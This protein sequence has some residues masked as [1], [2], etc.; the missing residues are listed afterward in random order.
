M[1]ASQAPEASA[2][3]TQR[4]AGDSED[5]LDDGLTADSFLPPEDEGE[6]EDDED[7]D[8]GSAG[9]DAGDSDEGGAGEPQA[10]KKRPRESA[11]ESDG[12]GASSPSEGLDAEGSERREKK[13]RKHKKHKKRRE[14][15]RKDDAAAP[16]PTGRNRFV[17]LEAEVSEDSDLGVSSD[18]TDD[19]LSDEAREAAEARRDADLRQ[20]AR[21]GFGAHRR[22]D[23]Q[24][25]RERDSDLAGFDADLD[26][27]DQAGPA[28]LSRGRELIAHGAL[29]A[30]GGGAV[31]RAPRR[32]VKVSQEDLLPT[33]KDP[34]MWVVKCRQGQERLAILSLMQKFVT[35]GSR[36]GGVPV[37]SAVA[38]EH[39]KGY[40]YIEAYRHDDVRSAIDKMHLFFRGTQKL[41]ALEEMP[42][43]MESARSSRV[44]TSA[45]G[46][47]VALYSL[48]RG[49]WVRVSRGVFR[50]DLAQ[51]MDTDDSRNVVRLRLLPRIQL[52][53]Q[54]DKKIR[55][56]QRLFSREEVNRQVDGAERATVDGDGYRFRGEIYD[57]SGFLLKEFNIKSIVSAKGEATVA[58]F[59]P[60]TLEEID[61]FSAALGTTAAPNGEEDDDETSVER[62]RQQNS[63]ALDLLKDL[64]VKKV[65]QKFQVGDTV[66]VTQGQLKSLSGVVENVTADTAADPTGGG[67]GMQV[68][69]RPHHEDLKDD[70]LTFPDTDL[71]KKFELGDH[72]VSVAGEHQGETGLVVA[73]D[74][75]EATVTVYADATQRE[76]TLHA[77]DVAEAS[78]TT[79]ARHKFGKYELGD[80]VS[81]GAGAVGCIVKIDAGG[82][83]RILD[84]SGRVQ[85]IRANE[86]GAK[87]NF[88]SRETVT[89][90]Q[91]QNQLRVGNM[92]RVMGGS[93]RRYIGKTA[94]IKHL[95]KFSAFCH[96]RDVVE[97]AGIFLVKPSHLQ[98]LGVQ[99]RQSGPAAVPM[100][101]GLRGQNQPRG[102]MMQQGGGGRGRGRADP[103]IS[104][105]VIVKSGPWKGY[106]GVVKN[107]TDTTCRVELHSRSKIIN[108][109]RDRVLVREHGLPRA[110]GAP[111]GS[112]AAPAVGMTPSHPGIRDYSM[113]QT[114]SVNPATPGDLG[115]SGG[116]SSAT[117]MTGT[118]WDPSVSTSSAT[119]AMGAAAPGTSYDSYQWDAQTPA[120]DL[121]MATPASMT[122][123]MDATPAQQT[124]MTD[125]PG[126]TDMLDAT[127]A[128]QQQQQARS[129]AWWE[130]PQLARPD[131]AENILIRVVV[132]GWEGSEGSVKKID[133]ASGSVVAM[134]SL[135]KEVLTFPLWHTVLVPLP[136]HVDETE[137]TRQVRVIAGDEHLGVIGQ[138]VSRH[139]NDAI[140][141]VE[142]GDDSDQILVAIE[143]LAFFQRSE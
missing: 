24:L 18:E 123:F 11:S 116:Y 2:P 120:T 57:R 126:T 43:V 81:V 63:E 12:A 4:E 25:G 34:K 77:A 104:Q 69:I 27:L 142:G 50:G 38:P 65:A 14:E 130:P 113:D 37:L 60:P 137:D 128:Q 13:R 136:E 36:N 29:P 84:H 143:N 15:R 80:L 47:K 89:Y 30:P 82:V 70:L 68:T 85:T 31:A 41:V 54:V 52:S 92:V 19:D 39:L 102:G 117:P 121:P 51:V 22:M 86:I 122:P 134:L 62:R 124:P 105:T 139:Y 114:P 61:R 127:P 133:A 32:R 94:T 107:A 6:A 76:I 7:G 112:V 111:S 75:V 125:G 115:S 132:G 99:S 45:T 8:F 91:S 108:V 90:D 119:P 71:A 26:A 78:D 140:V 20:A 83:F 87:R 10:P 59:G 64:K 131:L 138:L 109:A 1:F 93:D 35:L 49:D 23:A 67:L 141:K 53:R 16:A 46:G 48:K 17:D 101:P 21:E 74:E 100:S 42:A 118:V 28:S 97:N 73:V 95:Y 96:S 66:V 106:V 58:G 33:V 44:V 3:M 55:P 79:S 9:E 103:L 110:S 72:V 135:T 88:V 40:I 129:Q 56:T 5:E 98:L